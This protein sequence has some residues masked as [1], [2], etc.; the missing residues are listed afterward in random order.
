[1]RI[2]LLSNSDRFFF[3]ENRGQL[4]FNKN[5][6][7]SGT[8]EENCAADLF[9]VTGSHAFLFASLQFVLWPEHAD[10]TGKGARGKGSKKLRSVLDCRK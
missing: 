7:A 3:V 9:G 2:Y 1:M 5:S 10:G 6:V 8:V 4:R